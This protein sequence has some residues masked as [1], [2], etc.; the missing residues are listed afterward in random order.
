[1]PTTRASAAEALYLAKTQGSRLGTIR[2]DEVNADLN[3]IKT[4][5]TLVGDEAATN[6]ITL[7]PPL[8]EGQIIVPALSQIVVESTSAGTA[9]TANIGSASDPDSIAATSD[10]RTAGVRNLGTKNTTYESFLPGEPV[11]ATLVT[12]TS[13]TAGKKITFYFVTRSV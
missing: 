8:K 2:G 6:V 1:M 12:S 3:V 11:I 9:L 13:P 10:L 4:T 7:T 5:I